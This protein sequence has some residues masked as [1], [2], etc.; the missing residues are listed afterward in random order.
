[1]ITADAKRVAV[2]VDCDEWFCRQRGL[3]GCQ[4]HVTQLPQDCG[5]GT[6]RRYL[7]R[8][9][10]LLAHSDECDRAR[11]KLLHVRLSRVIT[12]ALGRKRR[13]G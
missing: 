1:M 12:S 2:Y 11:Q 8:E 7:Q 5:F 9:L 13:G 10:G 6:R 3:R 4:S